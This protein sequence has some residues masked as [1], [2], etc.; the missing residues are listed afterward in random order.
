MGKG[1][2]M[3]KERIFVSPAFDNSNLFEDYLKLLKQHKFVH[4]KYK[5]EISSDCVGR[6]KWMEELDEY[7]PRFYRE[8]SFNTERHLF[9]NE[10]S[11]LQEACHLRE[12]NIKL[13]ELYPNLEIIREIK[14]FTDE[15][16]EKSALQHIKDKLGVEV[17]DKSTED[18]G[19]MQ[20]LVQGLTGTIYNNFMFALNSYEWLELDEE[21]FVKQAKIY[22]EMAQRTESEEFFEMKECA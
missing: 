2:D 13:K 12:A 20:Y 19:E 21:F 11:F 10:Q 14:L 4:A 9:I 22:F 17:S 5:Y 1:E 18:F 6:E 7:Y 8:Y 16:F 3:K 15:T